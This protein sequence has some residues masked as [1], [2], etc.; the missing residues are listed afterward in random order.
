VGVVGQRFFE[1]LPVAQQVLVRLGPEFGRGDPR[2]KL[3]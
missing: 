1:A 3:G 2:F